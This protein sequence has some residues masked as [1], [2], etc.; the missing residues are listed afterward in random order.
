MSMI[1]DIAELDPVEVA[2]TVMGPSQFIVPADT[3]NPFSLNT[4]SD[5]PVSMDSSTTLLPAATFPCVTKTHVWLIM[6][7]NSSS[8]LPDMLHQLV[9]FLQAKPT[10]YLQLEHHQ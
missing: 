3:E 9:W 8:P 7:A 2:S 10:A 5:S 1:L 4:G 6:L